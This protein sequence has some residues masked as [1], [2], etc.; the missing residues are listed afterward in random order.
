MLTRLTCIRSFTLSGAVLALGLS[1]SLSAADNWY[2]LSIQSGNSLEY[3][4]IALNEE[5]QLQYD[6]DDRLAAL[7][8]PRPTDF[9]TTAIVSSDVPQ[10]ETLANIDDEFGTPISDGTSLNANVDLLNYTLATLGDDLFL[11]VVAEATRER[12]TFDQVTETMVSYNAVDQYQYA[13]FGADTGFGQPVGDD[14]SLNSNVA[15]LNLYLAESE[16]REQLLAGAVPAVT[17]ASMDSY[18]AAAH[19][20]Y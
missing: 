2:E 9:A 18:L 11:Q 14:A 16:L 13:L 4:L 17:G 6:E 5:L 10:I 1:N 7:A 8:D 19:W 12:Y 3:S 15:G 20:N